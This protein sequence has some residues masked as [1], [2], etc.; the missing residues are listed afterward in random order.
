MT[1]AEFK[2]VARLLKQT[3]KE[4]EEEALNSGVDLMS[5]DYDEMIATVRLAVLEKMG[6]TLDEYRKMREQVEGISKAGTLDFIEKARK[7]I[8]ELKARHIPTQEEIT[9]IA[10]E[11]AE[12]HIKPPQIINQIVREVTKEKPQIIKETLREKVIEMDN[13]TLNEVK[14]D[15]HTLQTSHGDLYREV[16]QI[17]VP[18]LEALKNEI[19]NNFAEY[20]KHNINILG[21]PDWRKLAMGLQ[22]QIDEISGTSGGGF[23]VE[24]PVG[25]V[26]GSNAS[27]TVTNTPVQVVSDGITYFSGAGYSF[28]GG[29][30]TMDVP[31][32]SYI[33]SIY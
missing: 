17:K 32:S 6:F 24:T 29:T 1:V 22:A 8:E 9:A 16:S 12:K 7:E 15:L 28:A 13:S 21:M 5:S 14:E 25:T 26:N 20:F 23:N 30:I 11:V 19:N 4:V 27:F 18:D 3:Y 2:K 31:P 10:R 33:R